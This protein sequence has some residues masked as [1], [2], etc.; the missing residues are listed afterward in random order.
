MG[1]PITSLAIQGTDIDVM[2]YQPMLSVGSK[3][4]GLLPSPTTPL[5]PLQYITLFWTNFPESVGPKNMTLINAF[6]LTNVQF[7]EYF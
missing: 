7:S 3:T 4:V 5:P 6:R 1:G 2:R